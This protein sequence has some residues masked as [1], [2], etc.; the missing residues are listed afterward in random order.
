MEREIAFELGDVPLDRSVAKLQGEG[1]LK[2]RDLLLK[3]TCEIFHLK[4][5]TV[6]TEEESFFQRSS[7][8]LFHHHDQLL[9]YVIGLIDFAVLTQ[10]LERVSFVLLQSG[11][12]TDEEPGQMPGSFKGPLSR[13]GRR[14][15]LE[16][17]GLHRL[18]GI[19]LQLDPPIDEHI[20]AGK[21]AC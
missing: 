4:H 16:A 17:V 20:P 12:I 14:A 10:E 8:S 13:S 11:G 5:P 9:R 15:C 19:S 6:G 2:S 21:S 1:R 7:A 18:G 3:A